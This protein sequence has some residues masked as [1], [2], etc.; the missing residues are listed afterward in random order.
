MQL[1]ISV[2]LDPRKPRR[3]C[4]L[5]NAQRRDLRIR[6][7]LAV[8]ITICQPL[9]I[10]CSER[11]IPC[12]KVSEGAPAVRDGRQ[13]QALVTVGIKVGCKI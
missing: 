2:E 4:A 3:R 6:K 11:Q 9:K 13:P 10:D 12:S 5:L 8:D 1:R 7:N